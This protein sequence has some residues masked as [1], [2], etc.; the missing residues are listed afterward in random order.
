MSIR[1]A[2]LSKGERALVWLG[3]IVERL[4]LLSIKDTEGKTDF[5]RCGGRGLPKVLSYR[6]G[7]RPR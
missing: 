1:L 4:L 5:C 2:F 7:R 3:A 6:V